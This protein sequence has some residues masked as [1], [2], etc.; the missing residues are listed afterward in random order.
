M[1]DR[2]R[3]VRGRVYYSGMLAFN[4]RR[5]TFTCI[6]RNFSGAG[7]KIELEGSPLLPDWF[8][9]SIG[10]R[11]LTCRARLVW[12]QHQQAGLVFADMPETAEVHSLDLARKLRASERTNNLLRARLEQLLSGR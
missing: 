3:V 8:D 12:R 2:R 10:R 1:Q 9:F 7:A 4:A 11:D 5:S 6:V